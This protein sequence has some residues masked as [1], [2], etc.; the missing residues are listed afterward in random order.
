MRL[1]RPGTCVVGFL[2]A[3]ALSAFAARPAGGA[4]SEG[5][6][7]TISP[8]RAAALAVN[9]LEAVDGGYRLR[10]PSH[11]ASFTADGVWVSPA[12]GRPS[13]S[14]RLERVGP[15]AFRTAEQG[16]EWRGERGVVSLGPASVVDA[17]G[18]TLPSSFEVTAGETRLTVD[19]AVLASAAYPVTIDLEIR[20]FSLRISDMGGTGDPAFDACTPAVA[21]NSARNEYLVVWS[22]DDNAGG[23]VDGEFEIFF[24]RVDAATGAELPGNDVRITGMG[25]PSDPAF[26]AYTP[27]VAYNSTD[28]EYLVVWWGDDD[29]DGLVEGEAE[30]FGQR[31]GSTGAMLG[32]QLCISDMG[33]T[34]D[35]EFDAQLP[36]VAYNST[37]N[38]YLVVWSGDDNVGGLVNDEFEIFVQRLDAATGA[39]LGY[40]DLRISDM[41]GTGDWRYS[42]FSPEVAYNSTDNRYLVVWEGDD[43]VDGLVDGEYEIFGELMDAATLTQLGGNDFRISDMGG[44]GNPDYGAGLPAAAYNSTNNE[45]LVVWRGDDNVGGLVD[46]ELEIIGQRLDAA[47]G[48]ALGA[49]DFL[50][51]D[52][53]G[54]D[55]D[56][57][58]SLPAVAYD[59]TGNQYLV[60]WE[61]DDDT[62]GLVDTEYE[63]FGQRLDGAT[64]AEVGADDFRI[65]EMGGTGDYLYD[66]GLPAVSAAGAAGQ[67]LV[68]WEGDDNTGGLVDQEF[69]IFG[70]VLG[71]LPF[72][73][74]FE[75]SDTSAWSTTMP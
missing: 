61:G 21:Y 11:R 3:A 24:Q 33:G 42:A 18:T 68:A 52:M 67:Y 34:G 57:D 39:P 8:E 43:N 70:K 49:N 69:E 47:T 72:E 15:A 9:Q 5:G 32:E 25:P 74:G 37:N 46:D 14:W 17:A 62:G 44:T 65:S 22:A 7:A 40:N 10:H 48:A 55:P 36:A 66:A 45:Y 29:S 38:E 75:S 53:G 2:A 54:G 27:A 30:I 12:A 26:D 1:P 16:W 19:G 58:A 51:S 56:Y 50:I 23:Q 41:G 60:V 31:L 63:I 4:G 64:G 6:I 13:W 73:D 20:A 59:R 35:P 28:N 71:I